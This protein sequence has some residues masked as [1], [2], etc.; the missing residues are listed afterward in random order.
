M[1][2][3]IPLVQSG[4]CSSW[5]HVSFVWAVLIPPVCLHG[6]KNNFAFLSQPLRHL[7]CMH[8][9][10][11]VRHNLNGHHYFASTWRKLCWLFFS[12]CHCKSSLSTKGL[13]AMSHTKSVHKCTVN[14]FTLCSKYTLLFLFC[15][16]TNPYH[17]EPL[18]S[19]PS[20]VSA[21]PL[22][23]T[24]ELI[25][26]TKLKTKTGLPGSALPGNNLCSMLKSASACVRAPLFCAFMLKRILL[27]TRLNLRSLIFSLTPF[28]WFSYIFFFC[29]QMSRWQPFH[30]KKKP[31]TNMNDLSSYSHGSNVFYPWVT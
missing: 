1:A 16:H 26:C 25:I 3:R 12:Q 29:L 19:P 20:H 5:M 23:T 13:I 14:L 6:T 17:I 31:A 4:L 18:V 15:E 11:C 28:G 2:A 27:F 22:T 8:D 7:N 21:A 30:D 10:V 9:V 24:G